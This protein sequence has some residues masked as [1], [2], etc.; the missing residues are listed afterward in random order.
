M[1]EDLEKSP[2]GRAGHDPDPDPELGFGFT[3][4]GG[5]ASPNKIRLAAG[6]RLLFYGVIFF[7]L[8]A[9]SLFLLGALLRPSRGAFSPTYQLLGELLSFL[10]AFLAAWILS[11]FEERPVGEYG[12]PLNGMVGTLFGQGCLFGLAEISLLLGS[13]ALLGGYSFGSLA[14]HGEA[15][16][17]WAAFWG[18]FFLV[19]GLF[20]EFFF[21]GY[22]LH[23][24]AEG[25]G[26]WPAAILLSFC[27]GAVHLQN[28][29]EGWIGVASVAFVGLFWS[30]SLK[31]TGSLWFA[32]GMHAAFD[33]GETFLFSVPDS[34]MTF[35]GHLSNAVLHGPR[36]MTGGKA[37]PEASVFDFLILFVF[38]F[39]VHFLYPE[40]K[41]PQE[42]SD[43]S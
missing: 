18:V 36:W 38:F 32:V 24:L 9:T 2:H 11:L 17:K 22:S 23:T 8:W 39:A 31:R 21:R 41:L 33:F 42:P 29:G 26:F 40:K 35:P 1:L 34:G 15:I 6:W 3:A 13:I 4:E 37:G 27:F 43:R 28:S 19:V 30:F 14:Q 25:I 7:V 20:E 16:A 12:L 5:N 10:A